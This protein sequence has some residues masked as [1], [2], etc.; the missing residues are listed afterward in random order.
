MYRLFLHFSLFFFLACAGN[1]TLATFDDL[2]G[3]LLAVPNCYHNISWGNEYYINRYFYGNASGYYTA[4]VSGN[5][6]L[7]DG[8]G[9]PMNMTSANGRLFILNSVVVAAAW[10]DNLLLAVT[11]YHSGAII[12]NQTFIL[13]VFTASYINF[14]GYSG[15]D[16]V[17]FSTSGG[18][19]NPYV[20]G[21]GMHFAMDNVCLTF[22]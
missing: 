13:Q 20:V 9:N 12:R 22:I 4:T 7:Y 10:Y 6:S 19:R 17:V 18:T 21:N 5:N 2:P 14:S 3:D 1:G 16:T 15:L 8:D 11:G